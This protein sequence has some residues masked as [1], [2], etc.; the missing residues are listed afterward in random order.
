MYWALS[1]IIACSV[2]A[3]APAS[4]PDLD[5]PESAQIIQ[6]YLSASQAHQ[7]SLRGASMEVEIEASIPELKKRG[8]LH[9]L[10]NISKLGQITYKVLG[11]QG[12]NTIKKEVIARFLSAEQQ[13]QGDNSMAMTP[14][15]YKFRFKGEQALQAGGKV[16]VFQLTPRKKA[17]GLFKGEVWLDAATYLPVLEKGR[18]VK[19]PTVFFRKVDFERAYSIQNGIAIP[20]HMNSVIDTRLVGKVELNVSYTNFEP[21]SMEPAEPLL[22][23]FLE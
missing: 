1:L 18:M 4:V 2:A 16:Y 3:L 11:F 10:R 12:D 14:D 22:S 8:K 17:V 19:N 6:N 13:S 15:N 9:A 20:Q 5:S 23:T 21:E 7:D